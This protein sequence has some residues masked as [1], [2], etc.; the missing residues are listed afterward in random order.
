MELT[1]GA[2]CTREL[3]PK[4]GR[5]NDGSKELEQIVIGV[6]EAGKAYSTTPLHGNGFS[7]SV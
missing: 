4:P 2:L 5:L 6:D 1:L 7:R 3:L